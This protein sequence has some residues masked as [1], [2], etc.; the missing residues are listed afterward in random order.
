MPPP[1]AGQVTPE[2]LGINRWFQW[3]YWGNNGNNPALRRLPP[4]MPFGPGGQVV[5]DGM[6][7]VPYDASPGGAGPV[8]API[9]QPSA[10]T[11]AANR[12]QAVGAALQTSAVA[13]V[14][15]GAQQP[16]QPASPPVFTSRLVEQ[17]RAREAAVAGRYQDADRHL[18]AAW[19]FGPPT[20]ELL[21]DMGCRLCLENRYPEGER[22]FREALTLDPAHVA[23]TL[24]LAGSLARQWRIDESLTV[25]RRVNGDAEAEAN[26]ANALAD[27]NQPTAAEVHAARSQ[28]LYEARRQQPRVTVQSTIGIAPEPAASAAARP[29]IYRLPS[30]SGDGGDPIA[31]RITRINVL[32]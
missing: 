14:A 9:P 13:N 3:G 12:P 31:A 10:N 20:A 17:R 19:Q 15:P 6:A 11:G 27:M 25:F 2:P 26:L 29:V 5:P 8:L 28:A 23:A 16:G 30:V 24:N 1:P 21:N 18:Q 7:P 22:M 32:E 4:G